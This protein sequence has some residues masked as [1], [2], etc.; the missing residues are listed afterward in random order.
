MKTILKCKRKIEDKR[1]FTEQTTQM[2]QLLYELAM[3][4]QIWKTMSYCCSQL[5]NS[6]RKL[7]ASRPALLNALHPGIAWGASSNYW[8]PATNLLGL[9]YGLGF[10]IFKSSLRESNVQNSNTNSLRI[11][12]VIWK[13]QVY[14]KGGYEAKEVFISGWVGV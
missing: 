6:F 11:S 9:G 13:P 4:M 8:S 1:D 5:G 12:P 3:D 14:I 2:E 10:Y 7:I